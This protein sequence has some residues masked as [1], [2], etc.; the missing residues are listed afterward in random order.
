MKMRSLLSA[1]LSFCLIAQPVIAEQYIF[2]YKSGNFSLTPGDPEPP[3]NENDYDITASFLAYIGEQNSFQIP[4]K[5]GKTADSWTIKSGFLPD[6]LT[7]NAEKGIIEGV[8]KRRGQSVLSMIGY[9]GDGSDISKVNIDITSLERDPKSKQVKVFAHSNR[10]F[11]QALANNGEAY[12]WSP[13]IPLPSWARMN[14]MNVVG[15]P[16]AGLEGVF[17]FAMQGKGY[18]GADTKLVYGEIIV[19]VG[20]VIAPVRNYDIEPKRLSYI[21][22]RAS[23]VVGKL[24]WKLEGDPLPSNLRFYRDSGEISGSISTFDTSASMRF[25]AFDTDG[26]VGY[27]NYFTIS[28]RSPDLD[29]KNVQDRTFY[30][31]MFSSMRLS[32]SELDGVPNWK[33]VSGELPEGM[34]LDPSTGVISG[35]PSK[36]EVKNGIQIEVTS[37]TGYDARSNPFK[38]SVLEKPLKVAVG[39][40]HVRVKKVFTTPEP[41]VTNGRAPF[42]FAL[43]EGQ[44][45][46]AGITLN[47]TTGVISGS[48]STAGSKTVALQVRDA[49]GTV[50]SPFLV[51][52]T[53][54]N[55]LSLAIE[56]NEIELT[57]LQTVASISP[58]IDD[59]TL[60]PGEKE[61]LGD[62]RLDGALPEGLAFN[63]KTGAV[64]GFGKSKGFYGPLSIQVTDGSGETAR[65]NPFSIKVVEKA[66]LSVEVLDTSFPTY[67]SIST[68]LVKAV[69]A[70]GKVTWT[71]VQGT[72]P[73]GLTLSPDGA[74]VGKATEEG[75]YPG[76]VVR[77]TDEEA[78]TALS[79]PFAI[80]ITPPE[81]I[82]LIARDIT[83]AAG[84]EIS[85]SFDT[86]NYSKSVSYAVSAGSLPAGVSLSPS[87]TLS[88][89]VAAP[90]ET[91]VTIKATDALGR[92]DAK[93]V[94][95]KFTPPM[96][97]SVDASY[98][99]PRMSSVAIRPEITNAI[100]KVSFSLS[101][102]LPE[103]L[104]FDGGAGAISGKPTKEGEVSNI[105]LTATDDARVQVSAST[106]LRVIARDQL[107]VTY[108]FST[109]LT[110]NSALGLPKYPL[111]PT[112]AV[113][114]V[115]YSITGKLPDGLAF[116]TKNGAFSGTP[117]QVGIFDNIVVTGKD[118]EGV[119]ANSS[120]IRI[121]VAPATA[122]TIADQSVSG[123]VN[124]Y[125]ET[126]PAVVKGAVGAV[127]FRATPPNPLGMSVDSAT[128]SIRGVPSAIGGQVVQI[129]ATDA[130]GRKV[131]YRVTL[132]VVD[133]L[134]V[135]YS[136][137]AASQYSKVSLTP[138]VKNAIGN[139]E[140][141]IASG[142]LGELSID[143]NTGVISGTPTTVGT[144]TFTVLA[145]DEGTQNAS[146]STGS[147][148]VTVDARK[149][150]EIANAEEQNIFANRLYTQTASA[151]NA[152][153]A[154]TWTI[155]NG[156][157]PE[158]LAFNSADGKITGTPTVLGTYSITLKAVDSVGGTATK[159]IDYL[160]TT[161]GLPIQLTTYNVKTKSGLPF[162]SE[163]PLV[164][165]SVGDYSFYS[166]DLASYGIK[167]DPVTGVISGRFD[168]P[169]RV[170]GN[171]HVSDSTNRLTSK[172][173]VIEV[174][175]NIQVSIREQINIT[176]SVD[177]TTVRPTVE[178]ALGAVKY[179][180]IGP[181]LP[182][183][184]KFSETSGAIY[185]LPTILGTFSGYFIEAV[186]SVGDRSTSNGFAITIYPSGILPTIKM[187]ASYEIAGDGKTLVNITP[188]VSAKKE[189]DVYS[190]NKPL[191]SGLSIDPVTGKITGAVSS[192]RLGVYEGY[193]I[194]LTDTAGN[195]STSNEF[196]LMVRSE[197]QP[198]F[199]YT[200]IYTRAG[201][202]FETDAPRLTRGQTVGKV[203]WYPDSSLL[204]Y[205]K[206]DAD[207]G[208]IRGTVPANLSPRTLTAYLR[209][210]DDVRT[211]SQTVG[212]TVNVVGLTATLASKT[213]KGAI[214]DYIEHEAP[215]VS[216]AVGKTKFAWQ[217]GSEVEGLTV[218]PN[219]GV[220]SGILPTVSYTSR[221]IVAQDD[222]G[223]TTITGINI[224]SENPKAVFS[225][226]NEA[227]VDANL[228][229]E[230]VTSPVRIEG[231]RVTASGTI[232][233][234]N[235]AYK[236]CDNSDCAASS[237]SAVTST[238]SNI[239]VNPQQYVQ[240]KAISPNTYNSLSTIRV[241]ING[242]T[243][244]W[245]I[246]NRN[247][248]TA[249]TAV[250]FGPKQ[251]DLEPTFTAFSE[252]VQL[253]GFIDP[254]NLDLYRTSSSSTG[255]YKI[256]DTY[257][258]CLDTENGWI[259][260]A[261][262]TSTTTF[263]VQT[264][265]K[266]FRLK[267]GFNNVYSTSQRV[268]LRN[269]VGSTTYTI[270]SFEASTR[271][272]SLTANSVNFGETVNGLEPTSTAYSNIVQLTGFL[273]EANFDVYQTSST[274]TGYYKV[275]DTVVQ[276][277]DLTSG[278][279]RTALWSSTTN[280]KGKPGQYL[281]VRIDFNNVFS[282][283]VRVSVRNI[284]SSAY[285]I[286]S[287]EAAT[288]ATSV[289]A[290][291]VAFG[292]PKTEL[293][294]TST[295]FSDIVQ[296]TGFLDAAS[297]DLYQTSGASKSYYKLCDTFE[298]CA[299]ENTGW[300]SIS[301]WSTTTKFTARPSQYLR[302]K[303]DFNNIYSSSQRVSLRNIVSSTY[304]IGSFEAST[305][306]LS[307]T[308]NAVDLGLPQANLEPTSVAYSEVVQMTGFLD[309]AS[310]DAYQISGSGKGYYKIC[311]TYE[312][313]DDVASGWLP[314]ATYSST[315]KF[316]V[317]PGQFLRAKIEFS[318]AYSSSMRVT[319]RNIVSSSTRNIGNFEASTRALSIDIAPVNLGANKTGVPLNSMV[320]SDI[321]QLTGFLDA[322]TLNMYQ[323]TGAAAASYKICA[324][325]AE[326]ENLDSGWLGI[327]VYSSTT[328]ASVNP[329]RYLRLRI[330]A[331]NAANTSR[332][333]SVRYQRSG[334]FYTIGSMQ[335]TTGAN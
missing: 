82:E 243:S 284:V 141:S 118:A 262:W 145:K 71:L 57:R 36:A 220:I 194:S 176:A 166:D 107:R 38:M 67:S 45:L 329:G 103:G 22:P 152:V 198:L 216:Y 40:T 234:S 84:K 15:T 116:N 53:V 208:I 199:S 105:V 212:V 87:G 280:F 156:S 98:D 239:S 257:E 233:G 32:A 91:T 150:L 204:S 147:I 169:I 140:Y 106:K 79:E 195:V 224:T 228:G 123:R 9:S 331:P 184:I 33:L 86:R 72:L 55:P 330:Q 68:P 144:L 182:K 253:N 93:P 51:G 300:L 232:S 165:N 175:P 217:S 320:Y 335:I 39:Q 149:P 99:L 37:S 324:T 219:T 231:L 174:I 203:V 119:V 168:S 200:P 259:S 222:I 122:F 210:K 281:R 24:V 283:S 264:P 291:A 187:S 154:V 178:Y 88:G 332:T 286:G 159:T 162:T 117:R 290:D 7:L 50:S 126:P 81:P 110:E 202:P 18:T 5:P 282:G 321:V 261:V 223:S 83:W 171:I 269:T 69:S 279:L 137:T 209:F 227:V 334:S 278:W 256:C 34:I 314:L 97:M 311:Q 192:D 113:G 301:T 276:C 312:A 73:D 313:C 61:A 75:N 25:V 315:T 308:V 16:P 258:Q 206:L 54:Y 30:V 263:K 190:V 267:I 12:S 128:G 322:A 13:V 129:E 172:P 316:S 112:N 252:I 268:S 56:P 244:N 173:I 133:A 292:N 89:K 246:Q 102:Q 29:I 109:P 185:G 136:D 297:F 130:A 193:E 66:S 47:E 287:F 230:Y 205:F 235:Y 254:A 333:I 305:R 157:L 108:N 35:T 186:D 310:M 296:L 270:G 226:A 17:S 138:V 265:G 52:V 307:V 59:N 271:P 77:A 289:K 197:P 70:A 1:V 277:S 248:S 27:S 211:Y 273:D 4:L 298:A 241:T 63:S 158:G 218:D 23:N 42:V 225:F 237:W 317:E 142:S 164:R 44:T 236:I 43:A 326:C 177:M 319:F 207:T 303:I 240:L 214:G 74:I 306:P 96:T 94:T 201:V 28:T 250:D 272:I 167:L 275:C 11:E 92:S 20:P 213:I 58:K 148:T 170:T 3:I 196:A 65:S 247:L 76:I 155:T 215:V 143:R 90:L 238:S 188:T 323:N 285:T 8:A 2:R 181:E 294:P 114:D 325:Y 245:T 251:V 31:G 62:F 85:I 60:I 179:E 131:T 134:N 46:D 21:V 183:G 78:A 132:K 260:I 49:N 255:H 309:T 6:G 151:R 120:S 161:D 111:E 127:T 180:L 26:T 229:Q 101:G 191:P 328:S 189:G 64:T 288:R 80:Q 115:V 318:N 121:A 41:T 48:Y 124:T 221:T 293:E 163:L 299:V 153:G 104:Q 274:G 302:V 295:V 19:N 242:T 327:A 14:G 139:V 266:F 10:F 146:H 160:V 125:V 100:G 304:T 249:V 95:L 135:S